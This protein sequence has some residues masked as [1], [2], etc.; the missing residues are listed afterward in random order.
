MNHLK[1]VQTNEVHNANAKKRSTLWYCKHMMQTMQ[2]QINE[3]NYATAN[4]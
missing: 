2:L 3:A 1:Q 4:K